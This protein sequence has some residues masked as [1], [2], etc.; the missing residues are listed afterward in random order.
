MAGPSPCTELG[1][2]A[3]AKRHWYGIR[4]GCLGLR[5]LRREESST[6]CSPQD[7]Q[8]QG[9]PAFLAVL[10]GPNGSLHASDH[11]RLQVCEHYNRQVHQVDRRLLLDQQ[12]PSSLVALTVGRLDGHT[13]WWPHRSLARRQGRRVHRVEVSAVLLGDRYYQRVRRQQHAAANRCVRTRG[14]NPVHHGLV[15]ARRQ[16]LSIVY[17]GVAVHG[18]GVPQQQISA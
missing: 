1:Y 17:V 12:E 14:E 10:R 4:R 7:S 5:R 15:H 13:R 9:Q 16:L 18:G 3:Q 6:V 11:R 2:S 8:P